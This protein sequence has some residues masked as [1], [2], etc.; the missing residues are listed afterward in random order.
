MTNE[1]PV[2]TSVG[3]TIGCVP[4]LHGLSVGQ[5]G[6]VVRVPPGVAVPNTPR[7]A[8]PGVEAGHEGLVLVF[9]RQ[10]EDV[11]EAICAAGSE[12]VLI[13]GP[14]ADGGDVIAVGLPVAALQLPGLPQVPE[15]E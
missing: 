12:D 7:H 13:P 9:L 2:Q 3:P 10:V 8:V 6:E 1:V 15:N 11:D 4:Q 14:E 5:D